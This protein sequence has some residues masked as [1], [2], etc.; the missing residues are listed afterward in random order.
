MECKMT[1]IEGYLESRLQK[2]SILDVALIKLVYFVFGLLICSLYPKLL[3]LDWWYYLSLTV[4]CALPLW[5]HFMSL[6]GSFLERANAYLRT[7]T[8]SFQELLFLT[9]FFFAMM[10]GVLL[11]VITHAYWWVYGIIIIALSIK[12]VNTSWVW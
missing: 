8:P 9:L 1:T 12:P 6:D 10:M 11:P 4:L 3:T 5:F 7:N 2:F